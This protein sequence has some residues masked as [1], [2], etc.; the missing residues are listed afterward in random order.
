[1]SRNHA[2]KLNRR[3][4]YQN[5]FGDLKIEHRKQITKPKYGKKGRGI[6]DSAS[7]SSDSPLV[8]CSEY[9]LIE[10]QFQPAGFDP[11]K[12]DFWDQVLFSNFGLLVQDGK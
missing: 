7:N 9:L 3:E 12:Y 8:D 1:M 5:I 10:D 2:S 11:T 6:S 4:S